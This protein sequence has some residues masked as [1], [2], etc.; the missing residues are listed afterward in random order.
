M[1]DS[2]IISTIAGDWGLTPDT[3]DSGTVYPYVYQNN[4]S[5]LEF[6]LERAN[7]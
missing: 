7:A 3:E 5:D 6:V 1:K 4:L 2:D